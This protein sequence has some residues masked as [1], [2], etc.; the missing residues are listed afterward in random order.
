MLRKA[1]TLIELLVVIA[2]I[3]IL[4]AILFPV[5][6]QAKE[7]AKNTQLLSNV[8]QSGTSVILY[9][10]DSD[11]LFPP[12]MASQPVI[13]GDYGWQHLSQPYAKNWDVMLNNK[14]ERPT[15][16]ADEIDWKRI[17]HLGMPARAVTSAVAGIQ[18]QGYFQGT[19][20]GDTV[21]YD[22]IGGFVNLAPNAA[23]TNDWLGRKIASSL[24]SSQVND[25]AVT[26]LLVEANNWD[27]WMSVVGTA[28]AGPLSYCIRWTPASYNV[29]AGN[30]GTAFTALTRPEAGAG[31]NGIG[32][33]TGCTIPKG[34]TTYVATDS[35][36][37][38]VDFRASFYAGQPSLSGATTYK[39][40]KALNPSGL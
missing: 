36:A 9:S 30:Y 1:F 25:V 33:A 26:A 38:S 4:A 32:T 14:R 7:A 15:G 3:A 2:I 5:F 28:T 23:G 40:T 17:Q 19:Q 13:A 27:A 34:R 29:N 8:K 20:L 10:T 24:S 21:R 22:G 35:S 16:L 12:T 18:T 31:Y 6:A 39:V 11:D 37:K